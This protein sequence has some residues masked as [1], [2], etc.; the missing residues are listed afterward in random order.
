MILLALD[1]TQFFG[2]FHPLV[3]H[4]PIGIIVLGAL[5][6]WMSFRD[7]WSRLKNVIAPIF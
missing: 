2:R 3:I 1:W 6:Y 5:F 7:K 4:L